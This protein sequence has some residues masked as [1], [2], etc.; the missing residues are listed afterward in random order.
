MANYPL[1][2]TLRDVI[3]GEGF[4]AGVTVSGRALMV[5]EDDGYWWMY[6]VRP[7]AIAD[8]AATPQE[9]FHKF[10]DRYKTLLFDMAEE[11]SSFDNFK[12]EVESFY[13]Q[14]NRDEESRWNEAFRTI[15]SGEMRVEP[16]FDSLERTSP[17]QWPT[18]ISV[19]ALHKE[20]RFS[21]ADNV[22]DA[23]VFA[24]AA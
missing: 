12:S 21:P 19:V 6:G 14:P 13:G 5:K 3:T 16:P 7:G 23:Y 17:Q 9:A 22:P 8:F 11:A 18:G 2:F 20:K 10:R 1:M 24:A 15:R 4:L